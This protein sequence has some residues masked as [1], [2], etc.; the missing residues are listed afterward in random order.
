MRNVN[1]VILIGNLTR[2]PLA[3]QTQNGQV[4]T[5]FTVATNRYWVSSSGEQ[6]S[7]TEF[8]DVVAWAKLGEICSKY[9]RKSKL[10]YIEGRLKTRQWETE[11]GVK[12]RRT[13]VVATNMIILDK[14]SKDDVDG[15]EIALEEGGFSEEELDKIVSSDKE[16]SSEMAADETKDDED[17]LQMEGTDLPS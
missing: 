11:E 7:S 16:M 5:T 2:D 6:K 10:V 12:Q 14:R 13:E 8:T 4:I 17:G 1:K 9:L 3:R 15:D